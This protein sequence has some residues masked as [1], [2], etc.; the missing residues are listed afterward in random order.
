MCKRH[1]PFRKGGKSNSW[2]KPRTEERQERDREA[3]FAKWVYANEKFE[4]YYK[5]PSRVLLCI[6]ATVKIL[7]CETS[8][9]GT[10]ET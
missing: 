8:F 4:Q 7:A 6:Q 2:K 5:G 3:G 9:H 10:G 1:K